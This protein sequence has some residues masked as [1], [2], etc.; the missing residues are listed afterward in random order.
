MRSAVSRMNFHINI[1]TNMKLIK[2]YDN[3]TIAIN[4]FNIVRRHDNYK[5]KTVNHSATGGC[6]PCGVAVNILASR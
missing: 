1:T 6:P 4:K 5:I 3:R 2:V